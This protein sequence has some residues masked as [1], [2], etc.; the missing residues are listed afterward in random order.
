VRNAVI[1]L[2]A[3]I[4]A[5]GC[6]REVPPDAAK[7]PAT[8]IAHVPETKPLALAS[9]ASRPASIV[10]DTFVLV[11]IGDQSTRV[12]VS[13]SAPCGFHPYLRLVIS[14]EKYFYHV[15]DNRPT[16]F[17]PATD[18]ASHWSGLWST[19]RLAGDTLHFF[20]GDGAET[21]YWVSGLLSDDSLIQV[22]E[23]KPYRFT[24]IRPAATSKRR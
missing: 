10:G 20:Q 18:S 12:P 1:T 14:N 23:D 15:T 2:V 7:P 24:R 17:G 5:P 8:A 11:A 16:C 6:S 19:Y 13:D 4:L 22:S 9:T 3:S 21:F